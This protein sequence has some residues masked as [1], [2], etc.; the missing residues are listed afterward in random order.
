MKR[1]W[2]ARSLVRQR[3][4][5]SRGERVVKIQAAKPHLFGIVWRS[6]RSTFENRPPDEFERKVKTLLKTLD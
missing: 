2:N 5:S 6:S 4:D 3:T 1:R